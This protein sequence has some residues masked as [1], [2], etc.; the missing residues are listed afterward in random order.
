MAFGSNVQIDIYKPITVE[1]ENL[2]E[3]VLHPADYE[4]DDYGIAMALDEPGK[5]HFFPWHR[6]RSIVYAERDRD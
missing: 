6:I 3:F 4:L 1:I 2:S 5:I